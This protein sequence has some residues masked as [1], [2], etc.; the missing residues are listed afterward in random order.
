MGSALKSRSEYPVTL[1]QLST[2][3]EIR[4]RYE[5]AMADQKGPSDD[6][7]ASSTRAVSIEAFQ[8]L[9]QRVTAQKQ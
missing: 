7:G 2:D 1:D 5:I 4:F 8:T 6:S 9:T 3:L